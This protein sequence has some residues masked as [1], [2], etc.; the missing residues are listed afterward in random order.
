[1]TIICLQIQIIPGNAPLCNFDVFNSKSECSK[2]STIK[3]STETKNGGCGRFTHEGFDNDWKCPKCD[4]L[5]FDSKS[6]CGKC[7]TERPSNRKAPE[8]NKFL[9]STE[10]TDFMR[11][12]RKAE[13]DKF[14]DAPVSCWQCRKNG[15]V[16]N[17][18]PFDPKIKYHN[19]WKN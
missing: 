3:P 18:D 8:Y 16:Y 15:R 12:I 6:R 13:H 1:L 10:W 14:L 4:Y 5:V 7:S 11:S 9:E 17:K 2:C 19:C